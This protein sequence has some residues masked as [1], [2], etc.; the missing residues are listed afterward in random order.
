MSFSYPSGVR[1]TSRNVEK[2]QSERRRQEAEHTALQRFS[3][4]NQL[5][6]MQNQSDTNVSAKR[7]SNQIAQLTAERMLEERTLEQHALQQRAS[8]ERQQNEQLAHVM[9]TSKKAQEQRERE[10]Q[11]ICDASEELRELEALLKTAY[12]NKERAVQQLERETLATIDRSRDVAI[13][14]QMEY[15]RQ[16]AVVEMQNREL[17]KRAD[18]VQSKHVLQTQMLQRE[19]LRREAASD[20]ELERLKIEQLMQQ[21]EREDAAE[22]AKRQHQRDVT[23][24]LITQSQLEREAMAR[25]RLEAAQREEADV[26]AYQRRVE[27][28]E[29]AARAASATKKAH[30]DALFR[31][32]EAEIHAKQREE[33]EIETLRDELW[34]EELL[35]KKQQQEAERAAAKAR[36]KDEM[37]ASNALQ[38]RLKAELVARQQAEEDAFNAALKLKFQSEAR[39]E[40]EL[41]AFRRRQKETYKEEIAQHHAL[42]Q[43]MVYAEL[44]RE[45]REREAQ[46]QDEAYRRAVVEQAKQRLLREH[47]DVLQT[48]LPRALQ[49]TSGAGRPSSSSSRPGSS[50]RPSAYR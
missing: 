29:A 7:R 50:S 10:V 19:E 2:L 36:A 16:R 23:R 42:K 37:M 38:L 31:A 47:A 21:I 26:A 1:M 41:A 12:L 5:Q 11:R 8:R 15:D 48:Y 20:A 22:I 3:L 32:V 6:A 13:E 43:Q 35:Q 45:R 17:A 25:Q 28:R 9:E 40:M 44:E 18:A 49:T 4:G 27:A 30:E 39:R 24:E 33:A 46:E 34:A 14:Q